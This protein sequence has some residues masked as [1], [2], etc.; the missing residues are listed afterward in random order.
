MSYEFGD[1]IHAE[2]LEDLQ[3]R[4]VDKMYL[5]KSIANILEIESYIY[6]AAKKKEKRKGKGKRTKSLEKKIGV[7]N[8]RLREFYE[9]SPWYAARYEAGRVL[10]K[11]DVEK[12]AY[13][14]IEGLVAMLE[15]KEKNEAKLAREDLKY[16]KKKVKVKKI[17]EG[18]K[19]A[20]KKKKKK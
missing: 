5:G 7:A 11:D 15:S 18:A 9:K 14:W 17:R 8:S 3:E 20:L 1:L 10:G 12:Q 19:K 6:W 4:R 16:F 13:L 2:Y